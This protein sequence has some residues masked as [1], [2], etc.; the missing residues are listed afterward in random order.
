[1]ILWVL[2]GDDDEGLLRLPTLPADVRV[3]RGG[4]MSR[5]EAAPPP[6][7]IFVCSV[8]RKLLEPL[9]PKARGARWVHARFAGVEKL[10]FPA[11]VSSDVVLTN[12]KGSFSGSLA[13]F[14]LTAIL[15]FAKDLPRMR[16]S[17]AQGEW[18][19]F[20]V[21]W[22]RGKTLGIV[23]YGDIGRASARLAKAFGMRVIAL[24]RH[25]EPSVDDPFLDVALAPKQ[26]LELISRSDYVL[27][28]TPH[29]PA[30]TGI[31][32]AAEIAAMKP[33]GVLINLGRGPCVDEKALVA[34]LQSKRIRGAAL[35]VF[36]E[37]PLPTGHPYY[38]LDNLLLSPHCADH[39]PGW[40]EDAFE[41]FDENLRRFRRDDP[42]LNVVEKAAG[43]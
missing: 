31:V 39:T 2:A 35:D 26:K 6:D 34:A 38:A 36:E 17:Q 4:E 29:T 27:V 13:E 32:A 10:L 21:E 23:G 11:L 28:A 24:R 25:P 30:T 15:F 19:P 14:A 20:D 16:R 43:Y 9:W 12:G 37:E 3:V 22:A 33:T 8:G 18:D 41:L 7:A 42:L 40:L 1:L 5:F